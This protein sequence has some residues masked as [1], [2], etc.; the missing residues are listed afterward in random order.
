M[1]MVCVPLRHDGTPV[2]VLKVYAGQPHAFD[3]THVELLDM[4]SGLIGAHMAHASRF[5]LSEHERRH[6]PLTGLKNRGF[7]EERLEIETARATRYGSA[8]CLCLM[9]L[10]GFKE[11]NDTLGHPAGDAVLVAV[12]DLLR[13]G[14]TSDDV[15]RIGGDEFA[16][17]MPETTSEGGE[18]A[19][20]RLAASISKAR[21]GG[22]L[23]TV[24]YGAARIRDTDDPRSIHE[25][26]D[27]ALYAAKRARPRRLTAIG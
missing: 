23:I 21:L 13:T 15:F 6:D 3:E 1:S 17:L 7:Y 10:D 2:G 16:I 25:R 11:V 20:S 5:E 14:R 19:A 22:G 12:A 8:L 4:L 24:S 18:L 26:A 9:D 27:Q